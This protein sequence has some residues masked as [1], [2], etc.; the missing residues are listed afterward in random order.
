MIKSALFCLFFISFSFF[1]N[2]IVI[3][4]HGS[5]ANDSSWCKPGGDFYEVLSKKAKLL[6]HK[7]VP[8]TWTGKLSD[9]DRFQGAECLAKMILSYPEDEEVI[10]VGH[11]HGGNVINLASKLLYD[12]MQEVMSNYWQDGGSQGINGFIDDILLHNFSR[13]MVQILGDF[14]KPIQKKELYNKAYLR[15]LKS[16][17]LLAWHNVQM[18]KKRN[19]IRKQYLINKVYLLATPVNY[20]VYS[21]YM[22]VINYLYNLYSFGDYIQPILGLYERTYI[23]FERLVNLRVILKGSGLFK[24]DNPTHKQMHDSEIAK[25]ILS[26][27]IKKDDIICF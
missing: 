10:L 26:I 4:I 5:F 19:N 12:P 6:D 20:S 25:S 16:L 9:R 21:P 23:G 27:D 3:L 2:G 22:R 15:E 7:V 11:S 24:D 18:F 14:R 17:F 8:F 1:S 13:F